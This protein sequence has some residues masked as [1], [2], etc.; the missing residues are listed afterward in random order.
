MWTDRRTKDRQ[1][2]KHDEAN[3]RVRNFANASKKIEK[4]VDSVV[5]FKD[6]LR[7]EYRSDASFRLLNF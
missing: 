3:S 4:F 2:Y 6:L 5:L 7:F 1:T